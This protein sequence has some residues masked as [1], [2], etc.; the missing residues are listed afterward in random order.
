MGYD[1]DSVE[2]FGLD[3]NFIQ[4]QESIRASYKK[5]GVTP[6]FSC[7]PYEVYDMPQEGTQV[8]FAET[9]AAIYANSVGK[10]KTNK[11]SAFSALASAITGKSPYTDLRKDDSPTCQSP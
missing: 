8:A 6:S 7:I 11:E 5:M 4:K 10:L 1:K 3:E 2:K 9:N